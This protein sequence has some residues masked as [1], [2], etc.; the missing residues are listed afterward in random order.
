MGIFNTIFGGQ[1]ANATNAAV[2]AQLPYLFQAEGDANNAL[3]TQTANANSALTTGANSALGAISRGYGGAQNAVIGYGNQA[4]QQLAGGIDRAAGQTL[5][6]VQSYAPYANAG[7]G[8]SNLYNDALGVNGAAGTAAA[9]SAFTASPGYQFQVD[10]A[11]GAASR[12]AAATGAGASGNTL[13][14]IT[15]LGSNL[16]NTEYQNFLGNLNTSAQRGVAA[17]SGVAGLNQAAGA[18]EGT[19]AT[20]GA[21]LENATG[22]QLGTLASQGG[23]AGATVDQNL[24]SGLSAND[25]GLGKNLSSN[26]LNT[27]V[28]ASN[29]AVGAAK[30]TD[31]ADNLNNGIFSKIIGGIAGLPLG[32][33][34]SVGGNLLNSFKL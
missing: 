27:Q 19:G 3:N 24:G 2:N 20:T 32:G 29:L 28:D 12:A 10:Q 18:I 7:A 23:I 31:S 34:T 8:A 15:R 13:D 33:G 22:T 30:A 1:T 16:A 9:Q 4:Q 21:T 14:A 5:A 17:A 11:T 25:V 6:G 26:I